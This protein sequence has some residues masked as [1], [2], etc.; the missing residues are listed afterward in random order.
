MILTVKKNS[1]QIIIEENIIIAITAD[2]SSRP[3]FYGTKKT[4]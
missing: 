4:P 1:C 3:W 2:S